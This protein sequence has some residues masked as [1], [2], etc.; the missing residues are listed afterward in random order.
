MGVGWALVAAVLFGATVPLGKALLGDLPPLALAAMFYL[1]CGIGLAGVIVVRRLRGDRIQFAPRHGP[2]FVFSLMSGGIVAPI[3]FTS[4]LAWISSV[5]AALLLNFEV[6][7]TVLLA[8]L[9]LREAVGGPRL[10]PY[11]YAACGLWCRSS[12]A[13]CPQ[14]VLVLL[15][16][17]RLAGGRRELGVGA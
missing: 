15:A 1:G 13:W 2:P 5:S 14:S 12:W 11:G 7:F 8:R 10:T 6:V 16:R 9:V 3:P 4:G 17:G